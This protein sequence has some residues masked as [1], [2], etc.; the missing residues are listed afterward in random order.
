MNEN[1][2]NDAPCAA[3]WFVHLPTPGA[4]HPISSGQLVVLLLSCVPSSFLTACSVLC[5]PD[6][7][8]SFFT[9][10]RMP[11]LYCRFCE[12][13]RNPNRKKKKGPK[14]KQQ[15]SED[16]I[17]KCGGARRAL[18]RRGPCYTTCGPRAAEEAS[19]AWWRTDCRAAASR[20]SCCGGS[21]GWAPLMHARTSHQTHGSLP[22]RHTRHVRS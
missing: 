20:C 19:A 15:K 6:L 1:I 16:R 11:F 4:G 2:V 8:D 7:H 22:S 12:R 3:L 18:A 10:A 13:V 17:G 21:A 9:C 14:R 5:S